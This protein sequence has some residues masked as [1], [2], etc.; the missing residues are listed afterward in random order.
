MPVRMFRKH[1]SIRGL[2]GSERGKS[3]SLKDLAIL[4]RNRLELIVYGIEPRIRRM[5]DGFS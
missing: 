3:C 1:R 5:I 2:R 4:L